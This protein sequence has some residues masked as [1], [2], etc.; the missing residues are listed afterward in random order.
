MDDR[1]QYDQ[2]AERHPIVI[3]VDEELFERIRDGRLNEDVPPC[4][5]Y[6]CGHHHHHGPVDHD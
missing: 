1:E 4:S 5:Y 3:E 2:A 6:P